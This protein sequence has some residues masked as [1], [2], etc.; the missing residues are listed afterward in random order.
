DPIALVECDV[1]SL[2][3]RQ[4]GSIS[5]SYCQY[6]WNSATTNVAVYGYAGDGAVTLADA[7]APAVLLGSDG[8]GSGGGWRT[9]TL[10]VATVLS[11]AGATGYLGLRV[12]TGGN[13]AEVQFYGP[14]GSS[15]LKLDF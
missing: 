3:A 13:F 5:L 7:S 8:V 11:L 10:D 12:Q 4:S 15:P 6:Y 14:Q 2:P 1:R 9:L